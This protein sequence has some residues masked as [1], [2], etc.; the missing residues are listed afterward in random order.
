MKWHGVFPAA[1]TLF[2]DDGSI[3]DELNARIFAAPISDGHA[4]ICQN[5]T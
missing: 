4:L 3:N 5:L 1:S 2:T